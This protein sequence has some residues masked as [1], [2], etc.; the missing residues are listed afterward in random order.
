[1]YFQ[2]VCDDLAGMQVS[3]QRKS[4]KRLFFR[5]HRLLGLDTL[6]QHCCGS[7]QIFMLLE[8]N[9]LNF[10]SLAC[11]HAFG[12]MDQNGRISRNGRILHIGMKLKLY[13]RTTYM[14]EK[15][16]DNNICHSI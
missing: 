14:K 1:M 4:F 13:K 6:V 15:Y 11:L 9:A 7:I 16:I 8:H 3:F 5:L 2:D 12:A 10:H